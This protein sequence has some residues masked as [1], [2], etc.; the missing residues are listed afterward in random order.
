[1]LQPIPDK[2]LLPSLKKRFLQP[3]FETFNRDFYTFFRVFMLHQGYLDMYMFQLELNCKS[4][5][6]WESLF[7]SENFRIYNHSWTL[8]TL[9]E[10]GHIWR[11]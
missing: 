6:Q 7:F 11:V 4:F 5:K 8:L 9:T 2:M 10:P 1:M 3:S